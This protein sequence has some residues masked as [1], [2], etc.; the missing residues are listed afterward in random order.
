M[1][2]GACVIILCCIFSEKAS[3]QQ[4][5]VGDSL[6]LRNASEV[7]W[8]YGRLL[9]QDDSMFTLR[10]GA[11]TLRLA[12]AD[13]RRADRWKRNSPMSILLVASISSLA[14][15]IGYNAA[16]TKQERTAGAYW[17]WYIGGAAGGALLGFIGYNIWPGQWRTVFDR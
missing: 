10:S 4:V 14:A 17:T 11:D 12:I 5:F 3:S 9:R 6:R 8:N 13:L 16:T 2:R 7:S 15:G 1:Y